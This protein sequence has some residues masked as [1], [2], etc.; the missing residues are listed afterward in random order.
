MIKLQEKHLSDR[1]VSIVPFVEEI[2]NCY[3]EYTKTVIKD[4]AIPDVLDG[5]KPVQRRILYAMGEMGLRSSSKHAKVARVSGNVMGLYH[6]FS[7]CSPTI[8]RLAQDWSLRLPLID[9]HGNFG[10]PEDDAASDRY[11]EC[12][13]SK[14]GELLVEKEYENCISYSDNYDGTTKEPDVLSSKLP[15]LLI[16]GVSGI[17]VGYATYIPS[18]N[19]INVLDACLDLLKNEDIS[20][21]DVQKRL[22]GPDF[23]TGGVI[24]YSK[25]IDDVYRTGNGSIQIAGR[26]RKLPNGSVEVYELPNGVGPTAFISKVEAAI[27]SGKLKSILSVQDFSD[28][29]GMSVVL[30]CRRVDLTEVEIE[31]KRFTNYQVSIKYNC[32]VLHDDRPKLLSFKSMILHWINYRKELVTSKLLNEAIKLDKDIEI[33]LAEVFF[34]ENPK[35]IMD[36]IYEKDR[37]TAVRNLKSINPDLTDDQI[38]HIFACSLSKL[39]KLS[40]EELQENL[41]KKRSRL[42]D[43]NHTLQSDESVKVLMKNELLEL[44]HD[45]LKDDFCRRKTTVQIQ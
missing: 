38:K 13:L 37:D 15:M 1:N 26:L 14:Y 31:L 3:R 40:I 43:I 35:R 12:R 18:H 22:I 32:I 6:P 24:Q 20:H 8:V 23:N 19:P 44:R 10:S 28:K 36:V 29:R 45:L 25:D 30:Q 17:A 4:R 27:E 34:V 5:L 21:E 2:T 9:G 33:L 11:L 42:L 7:S 41:S 39:L 16:N